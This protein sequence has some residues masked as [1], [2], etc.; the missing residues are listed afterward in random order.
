MEDVPD[1]LGLS[2]TI[3]E[4]MQWVDRGL[5]VW[6]VE[7]SANTTAEAIDAFLGGRCGQT[8]SGTVGCSRVGWG[9]DP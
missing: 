8:P 2:V 6:M 7:G 5:P 4:L 1:V 9:G 3:Q